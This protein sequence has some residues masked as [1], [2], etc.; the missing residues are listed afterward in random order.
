MPNRPLGC[1]RPG[2]KQVRA[3]GGDDAVRRIPLG[4]IPHPSEERAPASGGG[5]GAA[6]AAAAAAAGPAAEAANGGAG[7]QQAQQRQQRQ[8]GQQHQQQQWQRRG[9]AAV[10][11]DGVAEFSEIAVAAGG[12]GRFPGS[13][14]MP[15]IRQFVG[16]G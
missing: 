10:L 5:S 1:C 8:Q 9:P 13:Q 12:L 11:G 14:V 2:S 4:P 16:L 15:L 3:L 7:Q 6:A